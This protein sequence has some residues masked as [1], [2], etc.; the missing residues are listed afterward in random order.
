MNLKS[1]LANKG[2]ILL[3]TQTQARI[4]HTPS[5]EACSLCW[6]NPWI[7]ISHSGGTNFNRLRH[8]HKLP[9]CFMTPI[10]R[11]LCEWTHMLVV[12]TTNAMIYSE[13]AESV[14]Q[15]EIL[16]ESVIVTNTSVTTLVCLV[17]STQIISHREKAALLLRPTLWLLSDWS[18][19]V[20]PTL[21]I[22]RKHTEN[23]EQ[24]TKPV[25]IAT[26][27]IDVDI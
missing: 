23:T 8:K 26:S 4:L 7:P 21:V 11:R 25:K 5:D 3:T 24:S 10:R 16:L 15:N 19:F 14:W 18:V 9:N 12:F 6:I 2:S 22:Q 27:R 13:P 20:Y 1:A 17:H